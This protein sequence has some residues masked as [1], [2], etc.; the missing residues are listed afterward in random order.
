MEKIKVSHKNRD[1]SVTISEIP[2]GH[3]ALV[4]KN[5][6]EWY[7]PEGEEA[8]KLA[9]TIDFELVPIGTSKKD[10]EEFEKKKGQIGKPADNFHNQMEA[11]LRGRPK[12]EEIKKEETP[13]KEYT[14]EEY[15][16]MTPD[17][18]DAVIGNLNLSDEMKAQVRIVKKREEK[19]KQIILLS[20]KVE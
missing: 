10:V 13:P 16:V 7:T 6:P 2:L 18:L 4:E 9:K 8:K 5:H 1:G 17:Q 20:K 3:Y 12:T 19:I 15:S 11:A 14:E